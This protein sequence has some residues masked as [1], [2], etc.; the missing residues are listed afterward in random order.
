[1]L[2][3]KFWAAFQAVWSTYAPA[4]IGSAVALVYIGSR[5]VRTLLLAYFSGAATGHYV[6]RG[7][8]EM[9]ELGPFLTDCVM[10][11]VALFAFAVTPVLFTFVRQDLPT[12]LR[13]WIGAGGGLKALGSLLLESL[14]NRS[15]KT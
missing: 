3:S 11:G 5:D 4:M 13:D 1:M 9:L 15:R 2:A 7:L 6:G 8:A 10:F 14:K 12:I